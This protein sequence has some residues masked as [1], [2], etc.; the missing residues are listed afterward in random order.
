MQQPSQIS[1]PE[2][3]DKPAS[4]CLRK[5]HGT[6]HNVSHDVFVWLC[7]HVA[8]VIFACLSAGIMLHVGRGDVFVMILYL[9]CVSSD[10]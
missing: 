2:Q 9:R 7:K 6:Q 8:G 4:G 3:S 5:P 10:Y 1:Q